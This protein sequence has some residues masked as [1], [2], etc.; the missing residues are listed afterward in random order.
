MKPHPAIL[1]ASKHTFSSKQRSKSK[2]YSPD[3]IRSNSKSSHHSPIIPVSLSKITKTSIDFYEDTFNPSKCADL[4]LA[5]TKENVKSESKPILKKI[6]FIPKLDLTKAP[7]YE[8]SESSEIY[9]VA[10]RDREGDSSDNSNLMHT[11]LSEGS[12]MLEF[13]SIE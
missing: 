8:D 2:D 10:P 13:I 9:K 1:L 12:S 4:P 3:K 11:S 5:L 6:P 7:A